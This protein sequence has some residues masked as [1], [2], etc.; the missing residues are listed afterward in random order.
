M[1]VGAIIASILRNDK[2]GLSGIS[3]T[4]AL[5]SIPTATIRTIDKLGS[6]LPAVGNQV[7]IQDDL[8][9]SPAEVL[10]GGSITEV[11]RIRRNSNIAL[12]ETN[13]T[14]VGYADRLEKRLAGQY[15]FTGETAGFI[16][17]QIL[18]N[19]LS[20]DITDSSPSSIATGPSVNSFVLDLPTCREAIQELCNLTQ[21]EYYVLPTGELSFFSPQSNVCPVS[22]TTGA[23]VSK[24]TTRET[25][26][27]FCNAVTIKVANSLRDP[28]TET[29]LGDGATQSFNTLF[30]LSAAPEIFVGSPAVAQTIGIIGVDTGKDWYWQ[31]GSTEIR[32]DD[33]D[34]PI[35]GGVNIDVTYVGIESIIVASTNVA[36]VSARATAENNSGIYEKLLSLDQRL[37]RADAQAIADSYV[38]RYSA[39][40][41]VLTLETDT[42]LEPNCI[43]IEPGQVLS[44]SL[45]GWNAAGNYLIRSVRLQFQ[46]AEYGQHRWKC[47]VEAISGPVLRNYIDVFRDMTGGGG[48][49]SGSA[50]IPGGSSGAGTYV[51]EPA[52]LTASTTITAP[53]P[54]T[55]G[56]TLTVFIKQGASPY[57]ITFDMSSFGLISNTNIG[58]VENSISI[59]PFV[60]RS[61][62]L[63]WPNGFPMTGLS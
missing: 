44:V 45:T 33:A 53:I 8:N 49:A 29:F 63:W 1:G 28:A 7:E 15:E 31:E 22:I 27:D 11:E 17:A 51:Y 24:L 18:A 20:G 62:G 14:C 35:S 48:S 23:N 25:R 4:K 3:I 40:S 57:T 2:T 43:S 46:G 58:S 41:V 52:K 13:C 34:T 42:K 30:P 39:L 61:D 50:V 26:E 38:D 55:P 59:F 56:A 47:S 54:A 21:Y 16:L 6:F 9:G 5:R 36:S 37:T 19:S 12:L 32:Q 10:F 60:G